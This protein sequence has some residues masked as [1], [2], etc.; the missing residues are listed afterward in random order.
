MPNSTVD[1]AIKLTCHPATSFGPNINT[2]KFCFVAALSDSH[3]SFTV[4]YFLHINKREAL[5][6]QIL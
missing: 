5:L 6:N 1:Q 4:R 2:E 3:P